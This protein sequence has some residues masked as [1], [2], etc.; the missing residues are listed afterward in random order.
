MKPEFILSALLV[1]TFCVSLNLARN[2][3][4][5]IDENPHILSAYAYT[6][7]HI[8]TV[9]AEHPPLVKTLS[10][11]MIIPLHIDVDI[12]LFWK[13][14]FSHGYADKIML[15]TRLPIIA[16][17]LLFGVFLFYLGKKL[18]DRIAGLLMASL[19]LLDPINI[20]HNHYV[21]TDL[22]MAVFSLM[23]IYFFIEFI[24]KPTLKS[25]LISSV[26]ISLAVL[27]KYSAILTVV[28]LLLFFVFYLT[29]ALFFEE[30]EKKMNFFLVYLKYGALAF[31]CSLFLVG[32]FYFLVG[33]RV[34]SGEVVD[35]TVF[36]CK[37]NQLDFCP[38]AVHLI[39]IADGNL[40]T[41]P[42]AVYGFGFLKVYKRVS[43]GNIFYFM[44]EMV[45]S[46]KDNIEEV[47]YFPFLFVAKQTI[48]HLILYFIGFFCLI[49]FYFFD[50]KIRLN[51]GNIFLSFVDVFNYIRKNC[52][53][54]FSLTLFFIFY[55]LE[56]IFSNLYIGYR[57]ISP[58][59]PSLYIISSL[60]VWRE[61]K[62]KIIFNSSKVHF[63][64]APFL[65]FVLLLINF[66]TY[67]HYLSYFNVIFG[68]KENGY[69]Y[70]EPISKLQKNDI[71]N[72]ITNT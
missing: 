47:M 31:F 69:K 43:E 71:I 3:Y 56:S 9:N 2:D 34:P 23:A 54:E 6:K 60:I 37:D 14:V 26:F 7:K 46:N 51:R 58:L 12:N 70:V 48:V 25:S 17:Y 64:F 44:G 27:S 24:K 61:I 42:F 10:G 35:K 38:V 20:A 15:L 50:K 4:F 67:P 68:G 65:V 62:K 30:K 59:F 32:T 36:L 19:F 45:D 39:S 72:P 5:T 8:S 66:N 11:L 52:L 33:F 1:I 53:F 16:L 57:H 55:F 18:E 13:K 29:F 28:F 40:L 22:A 21:T 49:K 41:R 63:Y